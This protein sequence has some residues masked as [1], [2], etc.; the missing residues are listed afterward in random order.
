MRRHE[1]ETND[2]PAPYLRWRERVD[3]D[4]RG[5]TRP[6]TTEHIMFATDQCSG[7]VHQHVHAAGDGIVINIAGRDLK[8]HERIQRERRTFHWRLGTWAG[9]VLVTAV[10]TLV[11]SMTDPGSSVDPPNAWP[12]GKTA[13]CNDGSFSL[14]HSRSGTCARHEGVAHWRYAAA[15]PFWR[16]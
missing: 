3:T 6:H 14:S 16:Q 7:I 4:P 8:P 10:A 11:I 5:I 13:L 2:D 12:L 9:G 1:A 15:D